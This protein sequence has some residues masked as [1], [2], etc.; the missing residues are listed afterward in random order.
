MVGKSTDPNHNRRLR[1]LGL[2]MGVIAPAAIV[3]GLWWRR[4]EFAPARFLEEYL[5]FLRNLIAV[6]LGFYLVYQY[7]LTKDRQRQMMFYR[8]IVR[9]LVNDVATTINSLICKLQQIAAQSDK[10]FPEMHVSPLFELLKNKCHALD[11]FVSGIPSTHYDTIIMQLLPVVRGMAESLDRL[12]KHPP[13]YYW[14]NP[15]DTVC[16]LNRVKEQLK[17]V[18]HV[19]GGENE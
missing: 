10:E 4:I 19:L 1:I 5:K 6:Y 16:K 12:A 13:K 11:D 15:N 8:T 9:Q 14:H 17:E 3:S 7:W 2:V 18:H